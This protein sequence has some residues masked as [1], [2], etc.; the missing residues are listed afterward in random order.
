MQTRLTCDTHLLQLRDIGNIVVSS[1]PLFL[2]QLDGDA[3]DCASLQTLHQ[4]SNEPGN[5]IL[6]N[7]KSC[8]I[9]IAFIRVYLQIH[10][11]SP[12]AIGLIKLLC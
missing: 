1:L 2:L 7:L 8:Y 4:V 11:E 9:H 12:S 10:E 5:L 6:M 3:S